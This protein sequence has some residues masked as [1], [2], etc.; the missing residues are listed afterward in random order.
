M[1]P[2]SLELVTLGKELAVLN[3]A[4]KCLPQRQTIWK[5][6]REPKGFSSFPLGSA[7]PEKGQHQKRVLLDLEGNL[8]THFQ[9]GETGESQHGC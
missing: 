9:G 6:G 2:V 5:G 1:G 4:A 8:G 7:H 3:P